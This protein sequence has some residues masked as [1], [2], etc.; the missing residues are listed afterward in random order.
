MG[1]DQ[2]IFGAY[3]P[4]PARDVLS[5]LL[6]G[7]G[8]NVLMIGDQGQGTP[9]RIVLSA[10]PAGPAQPSGNP[11]QA[12]PTTRKPKPSS[13][14]L[15][16]SRRPSA[17][18]PPPAC[19]C[20]PSRCPLK[21][22]SASSNRAAP[23]KLIRDKLR[24]ARSLGLR[25]YRCRTPLRAHQRKTRAQDRI[26]SQNAKRHRAHRRANQHRQIQ[27]IRH[28]YRLWVECAYGRNVRVLPPGWI[29]P[30]C[31]AIV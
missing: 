28:C 1:Q 9:R 29:S 19:R 16:R 14:S 5:Q 3:G 8:Y 21:Y 27:Q 11:A 4:G 10:R 12:R 23:A 24:N 18:T 22:S 6:D 26:G 2:R 25:L 20:A 17:K 15:S 7:S 31:A 13:R 30:G